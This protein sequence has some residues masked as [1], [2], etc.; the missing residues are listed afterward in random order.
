MINWIEETSG[1]ATLL[2]VRRSAKYHHLKVTIYIMF[3][4]FASSRLEGCKYVTAAKYLN[5][6]HGYESVVDDYIGTLVQDGTEY[7]A[8]YL[9]A[10]NVKTL[11]K[12]DAGVS[13]VSCNQA[14][15]NLLAE[16]CLVFQAAWRCALSSPESACT[17]LVRVVQDTMKSSKWMVEDVLKKG[18]PVLLFQGQYDAK[19][20]PSGSEAWMRALDWEDAEPFWESERSVWK[21][22]GESAG[23]WRQHENLTHVV[24][25]GAGH[26]VFLMLLIFS[27]MQLESQKFRAPHIRAF[28]R[29]S[30]MTNLNTHGL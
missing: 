30:H 12:A 28:S 26:Q 18:Y 15:Q 13:W 6:R 19:D 9:N 20:G 5:E 17:S 25:R 7:L 4:L 24:L 3:A 10:P 16:V 8:K 2:D 29:R 1:V 27:Q 21:I 22:D 11:L 14:V 23:Y